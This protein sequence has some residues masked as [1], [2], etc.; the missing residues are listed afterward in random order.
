M[1]GRRAGRRARPRPRAWPRAGAHAVARCRRAGDDRRD[2]GP[3]AD[4][5]SRS[6]AAARPRRI[7]QPAVR[8]ILPGRHRRLAR[9]PAAYSRGPRGSRAGRRLPLAVSEQLRARRPAV[10]RLA[11]DPAELLGHK[12]LSLPGQGRR[13]GRAL[14]QPLQAAE[15]RRDAQVCGLHALHGHGGAPRRSGSCSARVLPTPG[16]GAGGTVASRAESR[17]RSRGSRHPGRVRRPSLPGGSRTWSGH[18]R[19]FVSLRR[20]AAH[21]GQGAGRRKCWGAGRVPLHHGRD[22]AHRRGMR[23]AER[24]R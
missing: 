17:G 20:R 7:R 13:A 10:C 14:V 19:H 12:Q 21:R 18:L 15:G 4:R 11:R 16:R 9:R 3:P 6:F 5:A 23:Q 22:R 1:G 8:Q 24:A 2:Q